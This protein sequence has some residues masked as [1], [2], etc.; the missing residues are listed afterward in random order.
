MWED[1]F[2]GDSIFNMIS[3]NDSL[4]K[5][6]MDLTMYIFKQDTTITINLE[7]VCPE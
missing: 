6:K 1:S 7:R 2:Y 3:I 5:E 4:V